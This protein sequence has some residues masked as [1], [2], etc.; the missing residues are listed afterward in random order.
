MIPYIA[1]AFAFASGWVFAK[2]HTA[3]S[4]LIEPAAAA[5]HFLAD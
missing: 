1:L 2:V 3:I 5:K 4:T